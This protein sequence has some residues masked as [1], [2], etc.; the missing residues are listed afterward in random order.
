MHICFLCN[1]YPPG[2]HGGVGSFTQTLGRGLVARG[3]TVT[4]V[5]VYRDGHEQVENDEGVRV[6]RLPHSSIRRSGFVVN[7]FRLRQSLTRIHKELAIDVLDGP[8]LS[9]STIS[10]EFPVAKVIRMNGGHHFFA[11]TLGKKPRPWRSWLERRSFGNANHFCAVSSFVG[12]TTRDLLRLN[13]RPIEIL[14]NPVNTTFFRPQPGFQEEEGL[15]LFVGTVC[16]KK[17]VRQL[18]H[19]MPKIVEAVPNAKL[20]IVG[21]HWLD[22]HSRQSFTDYLCGSIPSELKH[23][24][25]FSGPM[26]HS[27][28]PNLIAKAVVCVYPSH[29]EALPVAWLEGMAMGKAVVASE[30]GPGPEVIEDGISG[31]LC[32]PRD[33]ASI[34]ERIIRLLQN[35][36]LRRHLGDQA[37]RRVSGM[38]STHVLIERNERFY[39]RCIE[40]QSRA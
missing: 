11:V 25:T 9:L 36:D 2:L 10:K 20:Q 1:E 12:E 28:L 18:I 22:P 7:G 6:V 5:G 27:L 4:A 30:T 35:A 14:P 26:D 31:L 19:A 17:G 34:A 16:E 37:R 23:Q 39:S 38:F 8:E 15:I 13:D 32:N 21:R 24:I 3:H 29:M 40:S 33:P